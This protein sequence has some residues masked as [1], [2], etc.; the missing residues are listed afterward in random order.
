MAK[1]V[2][3]VCGYIYDE[4]DGAWE[5]LPDDWVCPICG[6]AKSEFEKQDNQAAAAESTV[7]VILANAFPKACPVFANMSQGM[8]LLF[9]LINV[10]IGLLPFYPWHGSCPLHRQENYWK[11]ER[12]CLP[13]G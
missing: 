7:F 1:Y 2:C 4:A 11:G 5:S 12:P 3:T 9:D 6:A 13:S 8:G 10:I